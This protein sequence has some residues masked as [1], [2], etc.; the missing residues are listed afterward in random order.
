MCSTTEGATPGCVTF[1]GG[2]GHNT[3][4]NIK[5]ST[6]N[7]NVHF[8]NANHH[9]YPLILQQRQDTNYQLQAVNH[10][11]SEHQL[12]DIWTPTKLQ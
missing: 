11:A 12:N 10:L 4:I 2:T 1:E 6:Q 3:I 7:K 9:R 5:H 8:N